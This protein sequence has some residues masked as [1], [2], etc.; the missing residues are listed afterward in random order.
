MDWGEFKGM[1]NRV[2]SFVVGSRPSLPPRHRVGNFP[3]RGRGLR[4]WTN[5]RSPLCSFY[6]Q[7]NQ[8]LRIE[9][10]NL[11]QMIL[12][13]LLHLYSYHFVSCCFRNNDFDNHYILFSYVLMTMKPSVGPWLAVRKA[14]WIPTAPRGLTLGWT[15]TRLFPGPRIWD[16]F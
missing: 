2:F 3:R 5:D 13:H 6:S 11:F 4:H 15:R 7:S 14:A 1:A 8:V 16:Q 9:R 10:Q 12:S